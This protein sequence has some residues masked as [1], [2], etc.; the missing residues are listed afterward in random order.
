M[1]RVV[2]PDSLAARRELFL[3][4][5]SHLLGSNL[6]DMMVLR[7]K[8]IARALGLPLVPVILEQIRAFL[9]EKP[10]VSDSRGR[11]WMLV[12]VKRGRPK[13]GCVQLWYLSILS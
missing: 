8:K 11:R 5:L 6:G 1:A 12:G 2:V 4:G 10:V 3:S 9:E 13:R 7:P